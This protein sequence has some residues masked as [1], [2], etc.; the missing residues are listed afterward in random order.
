M[1]ISLQSSILDSLF[2]FVNNMDLVSRTSVRAA[3]KLTLAVVDV[4]NLSL[5]PS[6][7][8]CFLTGNNHR[9][10]ELPDACNLPATLEDECMNLLHIGTKI[11]LLC[12]KEPELVRADVV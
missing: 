7:R 11:L 12:Y 4:D 10:L 8:M 2:V 9:E 1:G 6:E 3:A 5:Y